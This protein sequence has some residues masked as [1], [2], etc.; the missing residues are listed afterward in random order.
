MALRMVSGS[1]VFVMVVI[2]SLKILSSFC[3]AGGWSRRRCDVVIVCVRY[4]LFLAVIPRLLWDRSEC[5]VGLVLDACH[6]DHG[7]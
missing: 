7:L 3:A 4:F 5:G 2:M 1:F 6:C